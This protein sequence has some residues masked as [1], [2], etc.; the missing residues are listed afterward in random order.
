MSKSKHILLAIDDSEASMRAVRYVAGV[1]GGKRDIRIRLFHVAPFPPKMLE[2]GGTEDPK[3]ERQLKEQLDLVQ[4]RWS[5]K[6]EQAMQPVFE[7][8]T[9]ILRRGRIP[10][11]AIE[12]EL[13]MASPEEGVAPKILDTARR[14]RCGTI[15][16]G[17]ESI[18]WLQKFFEYQVTDEL[19]PHAQS[20]ALWVVQ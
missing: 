2:F 9:S 17:Q 8:A 6:V 15:V 20:L 13:A 5:G 19:I 11:A 4:D 16:V 12:T 10:A 18:S 3:H 7:R 14:H 1:L